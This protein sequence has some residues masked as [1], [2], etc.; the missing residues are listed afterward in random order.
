MFERDLIN[1]LGEYEGVHITMPRRLREMDEGGGET[2]QGVAQLQG[3]ASDDIGLC[4]FV[5]LET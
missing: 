5:K 4:T 2:V 1:L 3:I